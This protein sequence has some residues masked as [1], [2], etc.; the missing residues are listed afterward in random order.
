M[1]ISADFSGTADVFDDRSFDS[2]RILLKLS[3]FLYDYFDHDHF[4]DSY[5]MKTHVYNQVSTNKFL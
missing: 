5:I 4:S 1:I 2:G 3:Q